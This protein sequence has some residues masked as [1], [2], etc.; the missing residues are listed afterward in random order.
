MLTI[1][2]ILLLAAS[3]AA[4]AHHPD[5]VEVYSCSFSATGDVN[6]DR[7]PDGWKRQ[8]GPKYPSFLKIEVVDAQTPTD[9]RCL[10]VELDGG[11][12]L[13]HSPPLPVSPLF[14]YV[15]E[16]HLQTEGLEHSHAF[17]SV[18]YYDSNDSLIDTAGVSEQIGKTRGWT[19][20]HVGP[21]STG[22]LEAA[23]VV[24]HLHVE[25][26]GEAFDLSGFA[27]FDN[28]WLARLPRMTLATNSP[29]NVFSSADDIEVT[30]TVS[31]IQQQNP[32]MKFE[33]LD[34]HGRELAEHTS[35]LSG[36]AVAVSS[37]G[38]FAAERHAPE[39]HEADLPE[40]EPAPKNLED[41]RP[42]PAVADQGYQG[43]ASWKPPIDSFGFYRIRVRMLGK[44]GV[45]DA[46]EIN[47]AVVRP[48]AP[49]TSGEFGWSLPEGDRQLSL[50]SVA[51]LVKQVGVNWVKFPIWYSESDRGRADHLAHFTERLNTHHIEL[52]GIIDQPPP[53]SRS[54]FSDSTEHLPAANVFADEQIWY[55]AFN[56]VLTRLSLKVQSWQLG[57]DADTSFMGHPELVER[58]TE[59][60]EQMERLGQKIRLGLPWRWLNEVPLAERAPW[61]FFSL[62][63][64]PQMTADE[65]AT[66]L[67]S[68]NA[69]T[70]D[71]WVMLEPLPA[72]GYSLEQRARDLVL[73]MLAAKMNNAD[74]TFAT[75]PF[76][77]ETGLM[78]PDGTPG[79]LLLPWRT[80]AYIVSG[81]QFLGSLNL[82]GGSQNYVL[83]RG[84]EAVVVV[85]NERETEEEINLGDPEAIEHVDLWGHATQP[86]RRGHRQA[87]RV[88]PL[89][90]FI[91]GVNR[92]MAQWR[93]NFK[94]VDDK[95]QSTY[96]RSQYP[97][98]HLKNSFRQGVGGSM[99]VYTPESWGKL[100]PAVRLN[101]SG[102]EERTERMEIAL[103][104]NASSGEEQVRIDF[105][106]TSDRDYRFSLWRSM[107]IGLGDIVMEFETRVDEEGNLIVEQR[108]INTTDEPV[109]F[110]CFLFP[111]GRRR[112]RQNVLNLT[113]GTNL[114]I[115]KLPEADDLNGKTLWV[116]A[117]EIHGNRVL[118]Y[119][120]TAE[121]D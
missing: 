69:G 31:G 89:P 61:D 101:M 13:I 20:L 95:L 29:H 66:Y 57:T 84:D 81:T 7:W 30:C 25:P 47:L 38:D 99:Q 92:E 114:K 73:R 74:V 22:H 11:G 115:Y 12:A 119:R 79:E 10:Q 68:T 35:Q 82:P 52:V 16:G 87:Y 111:P 58:I 26:T 77:P 83:A 67:Q 63:A 49:N 64:D 105:D 70:A 100:P 51:D 46:K 86:E 62:I 54:Q 71:R 2:P 15:L 42:S 44:S 18:S 1:L 80:A 97:R 109:Y 118:N 107:E 72:S 91:T 108:M 36:Q 39:G 60:D 88:G 9:E 19:K 14:S 50:D 41:K 34:R 37:M 121:E 43:E 28:I 3:S 4:E 23:Y 85:W 27:R 48:H 56:P 96:G 90:T 45:T 98:F 65:I 104:S 17:V 24:I 116:R 94:L 59:V 55:P 21:F 110:K 103:R 32:Q 113:R 78:K 53:E 75:N 106:I 112:L 76:A 40:G 33:L 102:G 93:M 6:H 117:E 5:A 8:R 120:F